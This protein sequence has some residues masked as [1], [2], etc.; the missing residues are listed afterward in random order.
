[1]SRR[2]LRWTLLIA[3]LAMGGTVLVLAFLL[4]VATNNRVL[5]ERHYEWLLWVNIGV[6]TA[7]GLVI[8]V[9]LTRLAR[10][11]R[12]GKFG[13]K[14]LFKL[15]AIFAFVGVVPGAL[16]YGVSYQFVSRSIESWFD[17]EVEGAL[18]SGLNLGRTTLQLLVNDVATKTRL[19]AESATENSDRLKLLTLERL[20]EQ[21]SAQSVAL[22]SPTGQ[23]TLSAGG[24]VG[25]SMLPDRPTSAMMRQAR[26][27]RVYA[28]LEGLDA[29][30]PP[31]PRDKTASQARV[32]A[33]AWMPSTS[34]SL[35]GEDRYLQVTQLVPPELA[36]NALRVQTAYSEYQQR[37]LGRGGLRKMYIG[38]L[39]LTLILGVFSALLMAAGLGHQLGRPLVMLAEGVRQVAS[40]DLS[41]T[42]VFASR[43]E[44]GGLTRSFA[45]M[46]QQLA[47]ARG[48][49]QRSLAEVESA[50]THLQTILDNL[51]SGV[52]VFDADGTINTVNPG[53]ARILCVAPSAWAGQTLDQLPGLDAFARTVTQHFATHA[54]DLDP[55]EHGDAGRGHWQEALALGH[56]E[57][58]QTLLVR[59]A[60]LPEGARLIV[61]DDITDVVSAQR[62]VAWAE[63]ARRLAHEIKNPLTP[64]QLSAERLQHKL[65]AKLTGTDQQMLVRSVGTIVAQVQSMKTLVNEFRDYARLPAAQLLPL[66][67]NAL[68]SEVL[69]LYAV[70]QENGRLHAQLAPDLP[71]LA[72][73]ASQLRQVI[74][75]LVQNALDAVND[76]ADGQVT[77]STEAA[78]AEDGVARAIRLKVVDN[79]PGFSEK[80]LKRAF[81]PYVTTKAR[82]TGLGLA[83][84]KKIVEEHGAKIRLNNLSDETQE[85]AHGPTRTGAQVSISFSRWARPPSADVSAS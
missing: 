9:A 72:G 57:S 41:P 48:L 76:M 84:V 83:V 29:D 23:V 81:E 60:L 55:G 10:R 17:I 42:E 47:D 66:D 26:N 58:G 75:N 63:V 50:K 15:A 24:A 52:I 28:Q 21:L 80:I 6:A 27:L 37:A 19:A 77:I 7:L 25:A 82:G 33:I 8:L 12:H 67:L 56:A 51:T 79:G 11:M 22:L 35:G 4:S 71:A 18:E 36:A 43:D 73:D 62:S 38:T 64:I 85:T 68:V 78:R 46:T 13:S 54:A 44:L 74:H 53:A 65:E 34:F 59:G 61:F 39:T 14:L 30:T 3:L 49:V 5:Y 31:D 20:R 45:V 32:R 69:G 16:I 1:M 2:S 40:G 70:Q